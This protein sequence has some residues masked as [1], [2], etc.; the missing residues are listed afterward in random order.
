[1]IEKESSEEE[2]KESEGEDSQDE[3]DTKEDKVIRTQK[4]DVGQ[5]VFD[6]LEPI[7]ETVMSDRIRHKPNLKELILQKKIEQA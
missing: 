3:D 4:I 7:V 5:Y 6:P 2:K 1:M